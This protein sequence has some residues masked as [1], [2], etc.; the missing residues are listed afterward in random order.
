[1]PAFKPSFRGVLCFPYMFTSEQMA[2]ITAALG[3]KIIQPCPSCGQTQKR[4]VIGEL[5][6]FTSYLKPTPT[7]PPPPSLVGAPMPIGVPI[8]VPPPPPTP[9][10]LPCVTT[11]C[12]NCGFTE[13]YN[14]HKLGV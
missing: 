8:F 1:M 11:I 14:V 4:Q 2:A 13:F 3:P 6:L 5:F 7:I 10:T 9:W 12:N